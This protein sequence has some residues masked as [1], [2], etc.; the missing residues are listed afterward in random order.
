[1]AAH[2]STTEEAFTKIANYFP[3]I[4]TAIRLP[5]EIGD[6]EVS[7][8]MRH[9][10]AGTS[11]SL[12]YAEYTLAACYLRTKAAIGDFPLRRICFS[13]KAP[14]DTSEHQRIFAC[15]L[16]FESEHMELL[17][18]REVWERP[19]KNA[20]PLLLGVLDDHARVLMDSLPVDESFSDIVHKAVA[21]ELRGGE[22]TLPR[23]A[24]RLGV[25]ERTLQR[26][27]QA[28]SKSFAMILSGLRESLAREYLVDLNLAISEIAFILGFSE[29]SAFQRAFKRWTG[30]TPRQY[31]DLR[32]GNHPAPQYT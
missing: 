25:S 19:S 26:Q 28:E 10:R 13:Q 30:E 32:R 29:Q 12:P 15:P 24:Q 18:D 21:H 7:F 23:V 6:E 22:P 4:N 17:V 20:N 9:V 2:A 5:I 16:L 1:L 8:G 14:L 27:L 3:L 11:I 31:R